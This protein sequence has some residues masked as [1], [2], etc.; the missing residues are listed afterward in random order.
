MYDNN[1]KGWEEEG[2][3]VVWYYTWNSTILFD[4]LKMYITNSKA[5]AIIFLNQYIIMKTQ[6]KLILSKTR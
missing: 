4:M 2:K 3:Y 5:I 6:W 1:C